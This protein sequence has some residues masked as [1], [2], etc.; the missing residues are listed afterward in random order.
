MGEMAELADRRGPTQQIALHFIARFVAQELQLGGGL[1]AF[2]QHRQ[3]KPASNTART[4]VA[5]CSLELT[6]LMNEPSI[7]ILSNG[8]ARKF[9]SDE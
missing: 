4:M 6:D 7:L 5:A 8:N 1:D 3:P 9:E 2:G